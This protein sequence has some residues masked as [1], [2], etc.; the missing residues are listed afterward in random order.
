MPWK[1]F[2]VCSSN[3]VSFSGS[4][5]Y[6]WYLWDQK[7][8]WVCIRR[9]GLGDSVTI[10]LTSGIIFTSSSFF[11][12]HWRFLWWFQLNLNFSRYIQIQSIIF[13][14]KD[15][16]LLNIVTLSLHYMNFWIWGFFL[17]IQSTPCWFWRY[18]SLFGKYWLR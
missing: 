5:R 12:C 15:K 13:S 8:M 17:G 4:L 16:T 6:P 3:F 10:F 7:N 9:K 11:W 2:L 14:E 1:S 18:I